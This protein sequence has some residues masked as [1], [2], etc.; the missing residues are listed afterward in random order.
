MDMMLR[1]YRHP[2]ILRILL[3]DAQVVTRYLN[4]HRVAHG[5]YHFYPHRLAGYAA[6]LHQR[7]LKISLVVLFYHRSGAC[8]QL[9]KAQCL[10]FCNTHW[11]KNTAQ[12]QLHLKNMRPLH[13][14]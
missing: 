12:W 10:Y 7:Q 2:D 5:G 14:F 3:T 8:R 4:S 9:R 13:K 6:H 11:Y 1:G